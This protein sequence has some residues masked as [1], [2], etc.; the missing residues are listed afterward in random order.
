MRTPTLLCPNLC[1]PQCR[2]LVELAHGCN[3]ITCK[4]GAE[5]CYK[6]GALWRR[7]AA[8]AAGG[9]RVRAMPTCRCG[10]RWWGWWWGWWWE[11]MVGMVVGGGGRGREA[12]G[13]VVGG[14]VGGGGRGREWWWEAV[15][16][17][18]RGRGAWGVGMVVGLGLG[19]GL[20]HGVGW[21]YNL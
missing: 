6:C 20:G 8:G 4:C 9:S 2:A 21:G 3:H 12:V 13:M 7:P 19:L 14:M 11:G 1:N 15:G 17:G 18:G 10:R 5:W 16:G